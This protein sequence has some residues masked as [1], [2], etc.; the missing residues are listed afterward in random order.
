MKK[1]EST[2]SDQDCSSDMNIPMIYKILHHMLNAKKMP[3]FPSVQEGNT[4]FDEFH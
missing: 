4:S 1:G 3:Y 2:Q